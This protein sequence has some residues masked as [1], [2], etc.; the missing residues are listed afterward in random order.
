MPEPKRR[1]PYGGF[2]TFVARV[3]GND[4]RPPSQR[5]ATTPNTVPWARVILAA[6]VLSTLLVIVGGVL[7]AYAGHEWAVVLVAA[8]C[9]TGAPL[10]YAARRRAAVTD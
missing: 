5:P 6:R 1:D 9:L 2:P 3:T 4:E 7:W 10:T 8:G